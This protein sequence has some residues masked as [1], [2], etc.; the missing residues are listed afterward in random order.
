MC[1][2]L[3]ETRLTNTEG[4]PAFYAPE[5]V[6]GEGGSFEGKPIDIW[7]MGVTLYCFL[8]AKTPFDDSGGLTGLFENIKTKDFDLTYVCLPAHTCADAPVHPPAL[9]ATP[10]GHGNSLTCR[11][12]CPLLQPFLLGGSPRS[13]TRPGTF[14]AAYSRRIRSVASPCRSCGSTPGWSSLARSR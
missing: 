4:T 11:C 5:M 1:C 9:S 14:W 8:L 3:Q 13:L 2:L 6:R 12:A 7:T 10:G